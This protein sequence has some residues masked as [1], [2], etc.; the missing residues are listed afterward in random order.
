MIPQHPAA[1]GSLGRAG[2]PLLAI[3]C[4]AL[5]FVLIATRASLSVRAQQ[6]AVAKAEARPPAEKKAAPEPAEAKATKE[7]AARAEAI[8]GMTPILR[9][10]IR[11]ELRFIRVATGAS[12]EQARRMT[13][14][15]RGTLKSLPADVAE[16]GLK[17]KGQNANGDELDWNTTCRSI[18]RRLAAIARA[19]LS[20][21]QWARLQDQFTRRDE[22][23][24]RLVIR[25]VVMSLDAELF[26]TAAQLG[27][28]EKSLSAR[29]DPRWEDLDII[30]HRHHPVPE[31][32]DAVVV[33]LLTETQKSVWQKLEKM[34]PGANSGQSN[35]AMVALEVAAMLA[36]VAPEKD[37]LDADEA[38]GPPPKP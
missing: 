22:H 17:R 5:T 29:W 9:A 10:A 36:E 33:P 27:Q 16:A 15:A 19:E 2:R 12:D 11:A 21:D 28:L 6:P 25:S 31:I 4:A 35:R 24:K 3:G 23:R 7:A 30:N 18:Q 32:P 13:R 14:A 37:A 8:R 1:P 26:L 34:A 20:P 38:A